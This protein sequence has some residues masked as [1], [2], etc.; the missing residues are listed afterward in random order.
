[1]KEFSNTPLS[2]CIGPA[3]R[4]LEEQRF[5][6]GITIKE[7][8]QTRPSH[9]PAMSGKGKGKATLGPAPALPEVDTQSPPY[10]EALMAD[11]TLFKEPLLKNPEQEVTTTWA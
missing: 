8:H 4:P 1:M 9:G 11:P 3:R 6:E 10:M 5:K 7:G 2:P